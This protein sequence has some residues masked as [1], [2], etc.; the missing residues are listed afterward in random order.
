MAETRPLLSI[1]VACYAI[2]RLPDLFELLNSIEAQEYRALETVIVVEQS[3]DL[4]EALRRH[5]QTQGSRA[6]NARVLWNPEGN[7]LS[8]NRNLG[9]RDAKGDIIAFVDDDV[10]LAPD[11]AYQMMACFRDETV[12][13]VT[14]SAVPLWLDHRMEWIPEEFHW[15]VSCSSWANWKEVREVRNAWGHSMA[16]RREAF[17]LAGSFLTTLGLRG[18]GGPLA[19][20]AEFS[21][22][23]RAKTGKRI[24]YNPHAVVWHRVHPYRVSW[25][26]V[27][28]R[29]FSMG[30]SR[31][32]LR[33]SYCGV[34]EGQSLLETEHD[35]LRR[36]LT[37]LLP[38]ILKGFLKQPVISWHQ[39]CLTAVSL[40][41]VTLGYTWGLLS[42]LSRRELVTPT[43]GRESQRGGEKS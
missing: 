5:I 42:P 41:F 2:A 7:G 35:L 15:L 8:S 32:L 14:G 18:A 12:I 10:V 38:T 24:L 9:I 13:G 34:Q 17:Q 1:V 16:F 43:K 33:A 39:L 40:S 28:E 22:R 4:Y 11:W 20:D 26:Y 36:I 19:E 6:R 31:A 29:S 25:R 37:G 23:V 21:L 30:K 27:R 3:R